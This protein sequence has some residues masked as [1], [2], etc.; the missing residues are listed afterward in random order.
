MGADR[1]TGPWPRSDTRPLIHAGK[2]GLGYSD[3]ETV[4]R[5]RMAWSYTDLP[6]IGRFAEFADLERYVDVPDDWHVAIADVQGSTDA[7]RAGR[8]KDVN[9]VGVSAIA[10]VVNAVAPARVPFVF[11]GDGASFCIPPE[12]LTATRAALAAVRSMARGA[13]TLELR[14]GTVPVA[15]VRAAGARVLVARHRV[16]P[17]YVQAMFAG[18]GLR[19]AEH[20]IKDRSAGAAYRIP[21]AGETAPDC[22][23]LECRWNEVPSPRGETVAL[24]VE[25]TTGDAATDAALYHDVCAAID[26][27][28]GA[29]D[30]SHPVSPATLELARGKRAFAG[31]TAVRTFLRA[32][33]MRWLYALGVRA[34][35]ALGRMLF[36][37]GIRFAGVQWGCYKGEV[38][39]NTDRRKFD[40]TLRV[41]LA[42]GP[43]QRVA[44]EAWLSERH[45][46]GDLVY[47]LHIAGAAL[48]TCLIGDRAA[49]EHL[50]FV[51]AAGGG[52]AL[53]AAD[54]KRRL[55]S[56]ESAR[57]AAR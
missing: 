28:Y 48:M 17:T 52:Y 12:S 20:L 25:A 38:V 39:A 44:L 21:D 45:R 53:A 35:I 15:T 16:S 37:T 29:D 4:L 26:E 24:L 23:G 49:G 11:G 9:L 10:A 36:A 30:H 13:F 41:V 6:I 33:S 22:S 31:E 34:Q 14:V 19:A 5:E 42:G 47:G 3:P 56:R 54:L 46:R 2:C 55:A 8:Y 32:S 57:L 1:R 40:D 27:F 18:G 43:Q 7:I 51:D 50:H